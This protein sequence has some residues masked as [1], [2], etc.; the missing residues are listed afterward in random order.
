LRFHRRGEGRPLLFLHGFFGDRSQWAGLSN[1]LV[2]QGFSCTSLDLPGHGEASNFKGGWN[3][4]LVQI[5]DWIGAQNQAV[6]IVG[7]SMGS[8]ILRRLL[9]RPGPALERALLIAP[10]PGLATAAA[11]ARRL[12]DENLAALFC[13]QSKSTN[14]DYWER[15]PVFAGQK[16]VAAH[17]RTEQRLMRLRQAPRGLAKSLRTFGSGSCLEGGPVAREAS[18]ELLYGDRLAVD[19]ARCERLHKLWPQALKQLFSGC[20]H[21]LILEAPEALVECIRASRLGGR[22]F[23]R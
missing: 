19:I 6:S 13:A 21:N 18:I 14:I 20:G 8:R 16:S 17:S 2:E 1:K 22:P 15:L 3:E 7:Y 10:H 9:L 12:S 11:R 23:T 5:D 4:L